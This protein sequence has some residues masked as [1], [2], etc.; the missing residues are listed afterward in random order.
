MSATVT[1]AATHTK[2]QPKNDGKERPE[3]RRYSAK[4]RHPGS[5][6]RGRLPAE[7]P[8]RPAPPLLR[9][10]GRRGQTHP[11][12][13]IRRHTR[14]EALLP[15]APEEGIQRRFVH[16]RTSAVFPRIL[17]GHGHGRSGGARERP[18]A[19]SSRRG[20][21][22]TDRRTTR[23]GSPSVRH[24]GLRSAPVRPEETGNAKEVLPLFHLPRHRPAHAGIS[25]WRP[26]SG[27]TA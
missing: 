12:R 4:A 22:G 27:T 7:P 9:P 8:L 26:G 21:Q 2:Q 25:V 17:R 23:P 14:R 5:A 19:A 6:D 15:A 10:A 3:T 24:N 16:Q 18:P 11:R 13:Q 1:T 20:T